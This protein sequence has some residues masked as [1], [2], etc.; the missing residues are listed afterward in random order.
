MPATAMP[1]APAP[2]TVIFNTVSTITASP[3]D[4]EGLH[5][6]AVFVASRARSDED[7][8]AKAALDLMGARIREEQDLLFDS[9]MN[10]LP[11]KVR[12]AASRGQRSVS[13]LDFG[14]SDKFGSFCYVYLL[15]GARGGLV[16]R[17]MEAMG[18][19]PLLP[20][21]RREVHPFRVRHVWTRATNDNSVLL[22]W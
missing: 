8:R 4:I 22:F 16:Q 2:P 13:V 10:D 17:E 18:V 11:H 3:C 5:R 6:E 14:G 15:R 19:K 1:A 21:L 20:R 7:A 12:E 9:V